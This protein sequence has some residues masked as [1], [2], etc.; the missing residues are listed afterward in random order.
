[1]RNDLLIIIQSYSKYDTYGKEKNYKCIAKPRSKQNTDFVYFC[2]KKLCV[3][4]NFFIY[5]FFWERESIILILF[6]MYVTYIIILFCFFR[7]TN[8]TRA[9]NCCSWHMQIRVV[10]PWKL[11]QSYRRIHALILKSL[12]ENVDIRE[13]IIILRNLLG[14]IKMA[15]NG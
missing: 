1:M 3:H 9:Y 15:T 12:K 2:K 6:F 4:S 8:V 14:L 5:F 10:C 11:N 7:L 13:T